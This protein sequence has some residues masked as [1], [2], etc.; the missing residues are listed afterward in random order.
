MW[1]KKNYE[2][3]LSWLTDVVAWR[4]EIS[5][6]YPLFGNQAWFH[7]TQIRNQIEF[8]EDKNKVTRYSQ[9]TFPSYSLEKKSLEKYW[10]D[11]RVV[12]AE[13]NKPLG[14]VNFTVPISTIFEQLLW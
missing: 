6:E 13:E 8:S 12:S 9:F 7:L 1:L 2:F 14:K 10:K 5:N 11:T 3:S 4:L